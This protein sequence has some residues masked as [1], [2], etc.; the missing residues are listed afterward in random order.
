MRSLGPLLLLL[1]GCGGT[2]PH[3]SQ[4]EQMEPEPKQGA[5]P[6][7][8]ADG[9]AAAVNPPAFLW[10]PS[11]KAK[12]Y[13]LE[14]AKEGGARVSLPDAESLRSTVYPPYRKLEPGRYLWQVV[15]LNADGAPAGVS[16]RRTFT[17]PERNS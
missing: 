3:W 4:A 15:Y 11:D 10:T 1:V 13:R 12:T 5:L 14:L 9:A 7:H 6:A 8:P 16:K 17:L 2:K